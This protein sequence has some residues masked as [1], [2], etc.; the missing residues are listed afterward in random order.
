L[1]SYGSIIRYTIALAIVLLLTIFFFYLRGNPDY[2]PSL[3]FA[4]LAGA[5]FGIVLQRSRFC[6]YC[7]L[8][9]FFVNK[10]GRPLIGIITALIVGSLGYLVLFESWISDPK[11]GYIPNDAHIGP[12][13]W[14][15]ILGGLTF[16]WGMALSG[17]CISAHFY[18]IGEGSLLAPVALIGAVGGFILGMMSWNTLYVAAISESSVIW[19]PEQFGYTGSL[20]LQLAVLTG[21]LIWLLTRYIPEDNGK[22]P[23]KGHYTLSS[24]YHKVFVHRWPAWVGGI[25]VGLLAIFYYLR[26]EPLG[27]TAEINRISRMLDFSLVPE[28]LEGLDTLAGCTPDMGADLFTTNGLFVMAI[29]GGSLITGLLAGQFKPRLASFSKNIK[30]LIGGLLLGFG[31]MISLGCTIGTTLSG[32]HAFALSGWIFT[33]S[34]V[35]GV[36]S[37][38]KIESFRK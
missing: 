2:G 36:W 1:N 30:A 4:L 28:R 38:L 26:V 29:V 16:G 7:I 21:L 18:R 35:F 20:L 37:G 23:G 6:F 25:G 19:L 13:G 33:A 27:V 24:I 17:S 11:A 22:E 12:S 14:H 10:D 31:A 8:K 5:L 34:M 32:I 9:D 3:A 15:L